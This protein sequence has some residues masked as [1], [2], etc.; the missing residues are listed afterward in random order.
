M[1]KISFFFMI[2]TLIGCA[3]LVK[4]PLASG[5]GTEEQTTT[6]TTNPSPSNPVGLSENLSTQ[7]WLPLVT[8]E[9]PW[10]YK[11]DLWSRGT[12]L[13]GANIWQRVRVPS[14]DQDYLG[15]GYIG[16]PYSQADFDRL[17]QLGANY[18]NLSLPGLFTITPPYQ[19]DEEAVRHLDQILEQVA[20]ADLFA[21]I[22]F[23]SGP[24]R[25]DFTFYRDGAGVWYPAELLIETV[26]SDTTAQAAWADMWRYTAQ[27]YRNHP[28]VVGYTLM[29]EPNADEVA[30]DLYDPQAFYPRYANTTY[31]WNRFF[32]PII[33]AIRE[34]DANTPIL[35]SGMGWASVLWLPYLQPVGD[36]RTV[37]VVDQYAPFPYT[38]QQPG[39]NYPYPGSFDLNWDGQPDRFDWNWMESYFTRLDDFQARYA[40]PQAVNEFGVVRWAPQAASFLSDQIEYFER[41]GMNHA[42]W[43][44]DSSWEAWQTWGSKGMN[45]LYGPQPDNYQEV[46][47]EIL[48][49]LQAVWSRNRVHPSNF[50]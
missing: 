7:A 34:V 1:Q 18:V 8:K 47:N 4:Q 44:W 22:S 40:A 33:Q 17:A 27:R 43:V 23:R 38:H 15:D 35:L 25:S 12:Q 48:S 42:I 2:L 5:R 30:L 19:V 13:R 20:Q 31:D 3:T 41:R 49:L 39:Q 11:W 46:P 16:P 26:W 21:V 24:G 6:R 50:P 28:N 9:Q 32:P 29:V 37:F 36:P 45:Y 10:A 14:L